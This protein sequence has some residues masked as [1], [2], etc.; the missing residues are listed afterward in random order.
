[1]SIPTPT[2]TPT[3]PPPTAPAE[4]ALSLVTATSGAQ[5]TLTATVRNNGALASG[6][7]VK[8]SVK[9]PRGTVQNYTATTNS[10]G[11]ATVKD[12]LKPKDPRGAYVATATATLGGSTSTG[13]AGFIY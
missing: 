9:D 7:S 11:V 2:P 6:I 3:P 10:M 4:L 12:R 5:F 1:M 13:S 8:F